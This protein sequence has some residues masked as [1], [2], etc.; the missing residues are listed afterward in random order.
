MS[1]Q[2]IDLMVL[3]ADWLNCRTEMVLLQGGARVSLEA[4]GNVCRSIITTLQ[5]T[6]HTLTLGLHIPRIIDD[7]LEQMR[8][9]TIGFTAIPDC[10]SKL[11]SAIERAEN[12]G[13]MFALFEMV[14]R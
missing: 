13:K 9:R 8:N 7:R 6:L 4:L 3:I 14:A 2:H 12:R 11:T 10:S 5:S 1:S